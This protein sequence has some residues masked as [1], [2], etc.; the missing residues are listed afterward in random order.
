M[1]SQYKQRKALIFSFVLLIIVSVGC[2]KQVSEDYYIVFSSNLDGKQDIYRLYANNFQSLEQMTF[3]PEETEMFLVASDQGDQILY[4]VPA[5]DLEH[6]QKDSLTPPATYAH[7]YLLNT[8]SKES[9]ELGDSLGLFPNIPL[10]WGENGKKFILA[11]TGSQKLFSINVY[12]KTVEEFEIPRRF[13]GSSISGLGY[14][15]D[16][17][18][19]AYEEW[20]PFSG[21]P[22]DAVVHSFVYDLDTK[23]IIG[24]ANSDELSVDCKNPKWSPT[25]KQILLFC[26]SSEEGQGFEIRLMEIQKG[27]A[28]AVHTTA[29][30]PSCFLATWSPSGEK[31]AMICEDENNKKE[32]FLTTKEGY[33]HQKIFSKLPPYVAELSWSPNEDE[34]V[35]IAGE[36]TRSKYIYIIDIDGQNNRAMTT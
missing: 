13:P 8:A 17:Q 18:Q 31:I 32:I 16:A 27:E 36:N 24:L 26:N 1:N 15:Y 33:N 12:D 25:K 10:T 19:I 20:H 29:T 9:V 5:P 4:Y 14:S 22:P 30:F 35:Y 3:T 6:I 21:T 11:E 2:T 34:L 28:V 23:E 7:T